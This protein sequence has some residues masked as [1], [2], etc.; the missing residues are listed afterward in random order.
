MSAAAIE[1]KEEPSGGALLARMA[2][3]ESMRLQ[4]E[5]GELESPPTPEQTMPYPSSSS[6]GK[7]GGVRFDPTVNLGHILTFVGFIATGAGAYSLL[8]KRVSLLEDKAL[9]AVQDS[10]RTRSELK[11]ATRE[12][13]DDV[14]DV[15]RTVNDLARTMN[16]T[17]PR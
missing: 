8:E 4:R 17:S 13:R 6:D 15:Q 1:D 10:E 11:D 16:R 9:R 5:S 7:R 2:L 12:L 3:A 14:K